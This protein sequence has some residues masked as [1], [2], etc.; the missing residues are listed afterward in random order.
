MLENINDQIKDNNVSIDQDNNVLIDQ[1]NNVSIDQDNNVSMKQK[2]PN[3]KFKIALALYGIHYLSNYVARSRRTMVDYNR[4]LENYKKFI[5]DYYTKKGY[6]IDVL[7]STYKSIKLKKLLKN[8]KPIST[9]IQKYEDI[10]NKHSKYI[11]RNINVIECLKLIKKKI[12]NKNIR[13]KFVILTR[14]D[15]MFRISFDKLSINYNKFNIAFKVK[16]KENNIAKSVDDNFFIFNTTFLNAFLKINMINKKIVGH[17]IIKPLQ[18]EINKKNINFMI[19]GNFSCV[20]TPIYDIVRSTMAVL[21]YNLCEIKDLKS[22][23]HSCTFRCPCSILFATILVDK[24]DK[25]AKNNGQII[26]L[27]KKIF[28]EQINKYTPYHNLEKKQRK[29]L[30]IIYQI[31]KLINSYITYENIM[32]DKNNSKHFD[33]ILLA[34][35][36]I[37]IKHIDISLI[38]NSEH[39]YIDDNHN[40]C[41]YGLTTVVKKLSKLM[42]YIYDN[43]NFI[44]K[45]NLITILKDFF[46]KNNISIININI[47]L[48][49]K[50]K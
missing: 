40:L 42:T 8:Y 19:D 25:E 3:K 12:K 11:K 41:I 1:D 27:N 22:F 7:I 34:T 45:K 18:M 13:Y 6:E 44:I 5:F 33:V 10:S 29:I 4:S 38:N 49:K 47:K 17:K 20:S 31:D 39:V 48:I 37:K 35:T 32:H 30:L 23:K 24:F 2:N 21:L 26:N 28:V 15:L 36:N 43:W 46:N 50:K 14:F 9:H 16:T